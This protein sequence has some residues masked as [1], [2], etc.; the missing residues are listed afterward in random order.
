M[1]TTQ[2]QREVEEE[3]RKE[4]KTLDLFFQAEDSH[5]QNIFPLSLLLYL[6]ITNMDQPDHIKRSAHLSVPAF[7]L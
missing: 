5:L 4:E 3:Q 7:T 1:L 2:D 6:G